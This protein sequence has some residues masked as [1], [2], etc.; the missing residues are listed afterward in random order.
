MTLA[1]NNQQAQQ[2]KPAWTLAKEEIL[3][4]PTLSDEERKILTTCTIDNVINEIK[5]LDHQHALHSTSRQ[6][7]KCLEPVLSGLQK[8]AP[9]MDVLA[10][11]DPHGLLLFVWGSIRLLLSVARGFY[12]YFDE[13]IGFLGN[14]ARPMARLEAYGNLVPQSERLQTA[15]R[16]VFVDF[17]KFMQKTRRMFVDKTNQSK[18]LFS[19]P[20]MIVFRK[21]VWKDFGEEVAQQTKHITALW[22]DAQSEATLAVDE[23]TIENQ[24]RQEEKA[25][26]AYIKTDEAQKTIIGHQTQQINYIQAESNLANAERSR[27]EKERE[28]QIQ[29]RSRQEGE[30]ARAGDE[31]KQAEEERLR[32]EK[33]RVAQREERANAA[34]GRER[35]SQKIVEDIKAAEARLM[36]EVV[37]WLNPV[38]AL[39]QFRQFREQRMKGTCDW[40]L[41]NL[42]CEKWMNEELGG[43]QPHMLWIHAIPGAGKT[44]LCTRIVE[45]LQ[46]NNKSV[47]VFYCDIKDDRK[48]KAV[49]LL[50][51]WA[52]QLLLQNPSKIRNV[53]DLYRSGK[54]ANIS[55]FT[56][57]VRAFLADGE[58]RYL[59]LDALD[60]C[61]SPVRLEILKVLTQFELAKILITSRNEKDISR[62]M[63][64]AE[65]NIATIK[66]EV[67]DNAEDI[68]YYLQEKIQEMN[69]ED[70]DLDNQIA[71]SLFEAS[72]GMFLYARLM[73]GELSEKDTPAEIE[74]ALVDLPLDLETIYGR[75]L[76]RI[77]TFPREA[78]KENARLMLKWICAAVEPLTLD[79]LR[80]ITA[81]N[82]DSDEDML[83]PKKRLRST[84][85]FIYECQ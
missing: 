76:S 40:I 11:G 64:R 39:D 31:A 32:Q 54:Q 65:P 35:T 13:L 66:V 84:E 34:A 6:V 33:E 49:N 56:D 75:I 2:A 60:E 82:L 46:E 25:D 77:D 78:K 45:H 85:D 20:G 68:R 50:R 10:Q 53:A 23:A 70:K 79:Q 44:F 4:D 55:L 80:D 41:K 12:K 58:E 74:A 62:A 17:L 26:N 7:M 30:R 51:T 9:A 16:A 43:D 47:A 69:L 22:N 24:A 1:Q 52:W 21:N 28:D 8:Y 15:V 57:T 61:E 27:Q 81:F 83:N 14:I 59:V 48:R 3:K 38:D 18:S 19:R 72:T 29:E 36:K 37:D 67:T 42:T 73:I 5:T 63:A 71:E